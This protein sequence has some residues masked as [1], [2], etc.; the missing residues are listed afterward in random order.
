M[1]QLLV[2]LLIAASAL[3]SFGAWSNRVIRCRARC[4]GEFL[5]KQNRSGKTE[6]SKYRHGLGD[7]GLN[8]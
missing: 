5:G 4:S 7:F 8:K 3:L 6:T 1:K 2:P